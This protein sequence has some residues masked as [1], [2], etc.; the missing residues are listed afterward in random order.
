[1]IDDK[2]CTLVH[3]SSGPNLDGI[4]SFIGY[5][6]RRAQLCVF[7]DLIQALEEVG[8]RPAY[9][10]VLFVVSENPGLN[11]S[12]VSTALGIQ[13][14]NFVTMVDHL[15]AQGLIVRQPAKKDRRSHALHLTSKGTAVFNRA[16]DIQS[17]HESRLIEKLGPGGREQLLPLLWRI[18]E[19]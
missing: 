10:S 11:Q 4:R 14:T 9:F 5:A 17:E 15:E 8:L 3:A 18:A 16:R 2:E 7:D 19:D 6:L 1:M 13:R 12:E